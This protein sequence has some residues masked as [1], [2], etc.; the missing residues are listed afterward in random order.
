MSA[1]APLQASVEFVA[2]RLRRFCQDRL[3]ALDRRQD[4]PSSESTSG[5]SR[6]DKP[7]SGDHNSFDQYPAD[8]CRDQ[9][10]RQVELVIVTA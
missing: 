4:K 7:Q 3:A 9:A 10:R 5:R 8:G 1:R 6:V 2:R